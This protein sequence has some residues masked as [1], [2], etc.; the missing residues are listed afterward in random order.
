MVVARNSTT[1]S[2]QTSRD[3]LLRDNFLYA[4]F[5]MACWFGQD[6]LWLDPEQAHRADG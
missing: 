4:H 2:N 5:C 1:A 3:C 6:V